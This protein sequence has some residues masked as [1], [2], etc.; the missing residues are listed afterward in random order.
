MEFL[1]VAIIIIIIIIIVNAKVRPNELIVSCQFS[2]IL[3]MECN[4]TTAQ[5]DK[6]ENLVS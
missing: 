5:C 2:P 6:T 4:C 3:Q 1:I